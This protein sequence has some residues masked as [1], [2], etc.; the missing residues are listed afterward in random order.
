M[1]SRYDLLHFEVEEGLIRKT[2]SSDLLL[3]FPPESDRLLH[4]LEQY[5]N[6]P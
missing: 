3:Q 4:E 6:F 5:A 2:N 1:L